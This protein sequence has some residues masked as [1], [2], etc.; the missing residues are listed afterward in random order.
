MLQAVTPF[1]RTPSDPGTEHPVA[2]AG[3]EWPRPPARVA[4]RP[5]APPLPPAPAGLAPPAPFPPPDARSA[6]TLRLPPP[7]GSRRSRRTWTATRL[8]LVLGPA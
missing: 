7:L 1:D 5:Y 8:G 6:A 2:D 4:L 3:H